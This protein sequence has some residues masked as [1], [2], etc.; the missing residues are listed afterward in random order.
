MDRTGK[1]RLILRGDGAAVTDLVFAP[2]G[3][4]LAGSYDD[5]TVWLWDPVSGRE[6]G[7]LHGHDGAVYAIAF[8]PQGHD[9]P[10]ATETAS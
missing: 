7:T 4:V 6:L 8:D 3:H 2:S 5:G 1:S 9:W 10:R